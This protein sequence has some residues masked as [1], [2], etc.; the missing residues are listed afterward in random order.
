MIVEL[1]S[2][3]FLTYGQ[4]RCTVVDGTGFLPSD[5]PMTITLDIKPEVEAELARQTAAQGRAIEAVAAP[6]LESVVNPAPIR[7]R[8]VNRLAWPRAGC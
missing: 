5:A 4:P 7:K 1:L 6:L 8:L 2:L 3:S